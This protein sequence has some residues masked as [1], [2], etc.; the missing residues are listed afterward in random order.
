MSGQLAEQP[1]KDQNKSDVGVDLGAVADQLDTS[2]GRLEETAQHF[3]AGAEKKR[4][5]SK[6]VGAATVGALL[7]ATGAVA[8]LLGSRHSEG[9]DARPEPT[10][11]PGKS[12]PSGDTSTSLES[13]S[14]TTV[15]VT[16]PEEAPTTTTSAPVE[17]AP[18]PTSFEFTDRNGAAH[19]VEYLATD[20]PN[21]AGQWAT[22]F[23]ADY[24]SADDETVSQLGYGVAD[25]QTLDSL[26]QF[27]D[28][29]GTM[30]TPLPQ[31]EVPVS[32]EVD[33][34]TGRLRNVDNFVT[35]LDINGYPTEI[36]ISFGLQPI[37]ES[38]LFALSSLSIEQVQGE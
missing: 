37:G 19:T 34:A 11:Q 15:E 1:A 29:K 32:F 23:I 27:R 35:Y 38:D 26:N 17:A 2:N 21:V 24:V 4:K 12:L 6:R 8:G 36:E 33:Q 14:T 3:A 7:V 25:Q 30:L 20:D 10:E 16:T 5:W 9:D 22:Q 18:A 13:P 31:E 28:A